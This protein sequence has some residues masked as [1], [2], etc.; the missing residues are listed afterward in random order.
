MRVTRNY[1]NGMVN[2]KKNEKGSYSSLLQ[3]ALS[4]SNAGRRG[5]RLA[6]LLGHTKDT[7]SV[8]N[9]NF[10]TSSQKSQKFYYDMQYHAK[11]VGEYA[12][13]LKSKKEDSIYDKARESGSTDQIVSDVKSFV[14]QYNNMLKDLEESGTRS[15]KVFLTQ[16]SSMSNMAERDLELTGVIRK[17]DGTLV[18]DE[19]KLAAADVDTLE[20]VWGG[21]GFPSKAAAKAG[22]VAATAEQN[23]EAE[24]S[25]TY[26]PFDRANLYSSGRRSSGSY[27]NYRR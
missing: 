20:K 3:S 23:I 25:S 19:K 16:L 22:S 24:K 15:D 27:F 17:A 14:N 9:R 21:N 7:N 1:G 11:Q 2:Y 5:G 18:V 13:A 8:G 4:R 12:D 6:S 10:I 26:S